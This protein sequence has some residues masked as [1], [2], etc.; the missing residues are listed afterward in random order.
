MKRTTLHFSGLIPIR[1]NL[2]N[3]NKFS[4]LQHFRYFKEIYFILHFSFL[5][6]TSQLNH[7]VFILDILHLLK[8][9][10]AAQSMNKL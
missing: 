9:S 7:L 1:F 6:I 10:R 3:Q 5:A 4:A 2:V 8:C